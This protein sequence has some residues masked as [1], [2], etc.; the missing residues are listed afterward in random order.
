MILQVNRLRPLSGNKSKED[1]NLDVIGFLSFF[2][3]NTL[4][5]KIDIIF[6]SFGQSFPLFFRFMNIDIHSCMD[7]SMA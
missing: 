5:L 7:I 1:R 3:L 6:E 4:A 2:D